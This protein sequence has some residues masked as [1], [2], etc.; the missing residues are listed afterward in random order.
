MTNEDPGVNILKLAQEADEL[1]FRDELA[2][3]WRTAQDEA[4]VAYED[5]RESPSTLTYAVYRAA[6]DRADQAQ[7]ALA[8]RMRSQSAA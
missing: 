5:W 4:T 7:D 1:W 6:Q 2:Y 8:A 3:A